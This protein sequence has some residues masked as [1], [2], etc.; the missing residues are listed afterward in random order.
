M[1]TWEGMGDGSEGYSDEDAKDV[2]LYVL[3]WLEF[4]IF[5]ECVV[6]FFLNLYFCTFV[7]VAVV[8]R[9]VLG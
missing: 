9:N 3:Y 8:V 2:K 6:C 5:F 7:A 4:I 1:G